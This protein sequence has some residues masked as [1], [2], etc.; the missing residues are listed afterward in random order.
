[1]AQKMK[2]GLALENAT[3]QQQDN[4]SILCGS[5]MLQ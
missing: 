3:L 4:N 1:M 5:F 2:E